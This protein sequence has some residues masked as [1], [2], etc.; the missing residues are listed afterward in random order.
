MNPRA[1][2]P[3]WNC[4]TGVE[5]NASMCAKCRE[6]MPARASPGGKV[7]LMWKGV[8][9]LSAKMDADDEILQKSAEQYGLTA[10]ELREVIEI[11][12]VRMR[13]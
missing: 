2:I 9:A 1:V 12:K 7:G 10:E 5:L 4:G 6:P 3:C 8:V 11:M 13:G